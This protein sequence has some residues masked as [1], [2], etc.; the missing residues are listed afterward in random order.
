MNPAIKKQQKMFFFQTLNKAK[1]VW[2]FRSRPKGLLFGH[3]NIRSIVNKTEQIEHL[4]SNSNIDMLGISETGLT[5]TSPTAAINITGYNVFRR[6][7]ETGRVGGWGV[8]GLRQKHFKC[9]LI[10]WPGEI[11]IECIG[12]NITLHS[13]MSFTVICI[14]RPPSAKDSFYGQL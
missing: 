11:G 10:K 1:V 5:S 14:Y 9:E 13:A 6:D 2:D 7:R 12:L 4:L 3:I 8:V